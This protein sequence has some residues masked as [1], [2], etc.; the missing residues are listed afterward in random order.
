MSLRV[1]IVPYV[2]RNDLVFLQDSAPCFTATVC[3]E[4]LQLGELSHNVNVGEIITC[5]IIPT[6][7]LLGYANTHRKPQLSCLCSHIHIS[8]INNPNTR[9]ERLQSYS[10]FQKLPEEHQIYGISDVM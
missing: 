2:L 4:Y 10:D 6:Y 8:Y 9:C 7:V 5:S 3:T 1:V